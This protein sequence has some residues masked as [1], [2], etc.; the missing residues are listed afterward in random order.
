[1]K[2]PIRWIGTLA[3][4]VAIGIVL[5]AV[6]QNGR[7]PTANSFPMGQP[8]AMPVEAAPV[9]VGTVSLEVSMVGSL[10]A[11]ESVVIRSEIAGRISSIA[12]SEGQKV[13]ENAVLVKIDPSE[14]R[15][16][17]EQIKAAVEL[18]ELN[19]ERAKPLHQENL[20]SQQAYDEIEAKLKE[21]KANLSLA[22]ARLDKTV[23]RAPF[24]G[25]LGL[26][27]VSP[28]DYVQP[29]QAIVNLE[30]LDSLK[31]DSRIPEI[32]LA[33][34][35]TGQTVHVRVDALPD[36]TF[37]G[38]IYA[39]DPRIDEATR[40]IL[41]RARIPNPE[42]ALRPGIF[43]RVSLLLDQ[44]QEAVL[45]PEQAIVPIGQDQFVFRVVEDKAALTK[46]MIGLRREGEVEIVE[47][48]GANDTVVTAGQ[49]KI[50]DGA[51]IMVMGAQ[52][53]QTPPS[54][55]GGS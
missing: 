22:Q 9:R 49:T 25:R 8:P 13:S 17:L 12:F 51:S 34:V 55:T 14:Y 32:Y 40:T 33:Q 20:I 1:M 42:G 39:I 36:R 47:G 18:N 28:G 6:S 54:G 35:R 37:T 45:V 7:G 5:W 41:L 46:V 10:E 26:R 15:A 2:K 21:S 50:F 31:L 53:P 27:Q 3:V 52:A 11:N 30:D 16:Q 38:Q 44:R 24:G 29:G 23:I 48:L 19:F 43:A 4:V